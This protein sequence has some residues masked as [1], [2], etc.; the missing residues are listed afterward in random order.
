MPR[1]PLRVTGQLQSALSISP[2]SIS[3]GRLKPG[4]SVQQRLVLI[5][6]Q[7]F[8]IGTI[9]ADGWDIK[10]NGSS[11]AKKTHVLLT[12]FTPLAA[13]AG[14]LKTELHVSAADSSNSAKALVTA[15]IRD[16]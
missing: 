9:K 11:E 8:T 13:N 16:R 6:R 12:E 1:I 4:E 7:P 5:G 14:P 15:D 2:R 10:H 3:L